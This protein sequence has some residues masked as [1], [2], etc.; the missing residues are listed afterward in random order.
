MRLRTV[1]RKLSNTE[2]WKY[3][4]GAH[5]YVGKVKETN[6]KRDRENSGNDKNPVQASG[7]LW[8]LIPGE[9]GRERLGKNWLKV[10]FNCVCNILFLQ[11]VLGAL[12]LFIFFFISLYHFVC[13]FSFTEY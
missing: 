3:S 1:V 10:G 8:E 6:K 11:L 2:M 9:G 12:L 5:A 7:Y 4:L 13:I